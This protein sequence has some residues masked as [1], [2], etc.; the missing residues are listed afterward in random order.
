MTP[1]FAFFKWL[2]LVTSLWFGLTAAAQSTGP[3]DSLFREIV[4]MD[5][6]VFTAFNNREVQAFQNS[7]ATDLEFYHDKGG[8]TG[9][10]HTVDFMKRTAAKDNGLHRTLVP[11]SSEVYPVPG[12]GAMQ[13]GSHTFCH[14]EA[15]KLDCGTFKF[16]HIWKKT[17]TG[18]RITR[19]ISYG[20]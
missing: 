14:P 12:Y 17:E 7:F 11:G 3:T 4:R 19:V 15:G 20:H 2:F 1:D 5:S 18:W 6:V 9:Y 8:L 10:N 13:I 16:V